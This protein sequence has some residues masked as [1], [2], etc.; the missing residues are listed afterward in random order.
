MPRYRHLRVLAAAGAV[1]ALC[2]L[3]G[4]FNAPGGSSSN[5]SGPS[6]GNGDVTASSQGGHTV[7]GT[8]RV[9]DGEKTGD[10]STVNGSIQIG[11]NA[12]LT[13]AHTVNGS[14]TVGSHTTA[15]DLSS[16]N[17]SISLEDGVRVSQAVRTVNGSLTLE[18][19]VDVEGALTNVNGSIH[20]S[21]AHVGGGIV[22]ANGNITVEGASHVDGGILVQKPPEGW[23]Q[24]THVPRVVIGPGSVV[25]GDL[26][27][28]RK[29]DL[30][31]SD[32][33]KIGPVTGATPQRYPGEGPIG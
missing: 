11:D 17:G 20:L 21:A 6:F 8:V 18:S 26:R 10:L 9:S 32:K 23:F 13:S 7:N 2:T 27:F 1:A 16:V 30:Y 5:S 14:I 3:S 25:T 12:T 31:V 15:T 4:C 19:G 22:T 28:E 29:V 33:A 24:F